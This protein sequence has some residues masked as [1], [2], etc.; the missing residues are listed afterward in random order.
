MSDRYP[1]FSSRLAAHGAPSD[2]Q[3]ERA[4]QFK[5]EHRRQRVVI[6]TTVDESRRHELESA[7]TVYQLYPDLTKR[8]QNRLIEGN[9]KKKALTRSYVRLD[10]AAKA[11][12]EPAEGQ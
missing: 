5:A 10:V 2:Y 4:S 6:P 7:S 8:S 1:R 12:S 3:K 9:I 11:L